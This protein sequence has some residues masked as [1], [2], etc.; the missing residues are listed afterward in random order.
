MATRTS[1]R[2]ATTIIHSQT[3][4]RKQISLRER[5]KA[6]AAKAKAKNLAKDKDK[7]E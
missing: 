7:K 2:I 4:N 5:Q 6:S 3:L 1:P